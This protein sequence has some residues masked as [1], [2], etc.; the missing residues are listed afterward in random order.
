M[1]N[2]CRIGY[3]FHSFYRHSLVPPVCQTLGN[4]YKEILTG[5]QK[6]NSGPVCLAGLRPT[7]SSHI[8]D[9]SVFKHQDNSGT[10]SQVDIFHP[11]LNLSG[12]HSI[13]FH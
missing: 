7:Q 10:L 1:N 5:E 4:L 8:V 9:R 2:Y 6:Q 11:L 12:L 13:S 3:I